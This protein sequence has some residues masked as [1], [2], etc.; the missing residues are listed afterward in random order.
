MY[1]DISRHYTNP[2]TLIFANKFDQFLFEVAFNTRMNWPA[3]SR[4]IYK[5]TRVVNR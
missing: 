3:F 1:L 4:K 5:K 2:A